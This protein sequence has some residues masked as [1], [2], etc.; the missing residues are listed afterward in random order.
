MFDRTERRGARAA[1]V[2]RDQ[3]DIGLG[4]GHTG[5]DRPDA[6]L[7]HQLHR[8]PGVRIDL[9]QVVDQL[10]QILDRIDVVMRRRADQADARRRMAHAGDEFGDLETG[11][12]AALARLGAL[13]HLDLDLA[14]LVQIFGRDTEPA[15]GDLLDCAVGVVAV[16]ARRI[17]LGVLAAL[18]GDRPRADP[19]HGDVQRLVRL[20]RQG[21]QRHAGRDEPAADVVGALDLIHRHRR[22]LAEV[23]QVAQGR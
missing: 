18:A 22:G 21:T 15:G 8:H 12:L 17:A 6:R 20:G 16:R 11:Q 2:A 19:V 14:A 3:D 1:V 9:F 7:G 4:L 5:G 23:Q 13:G 10:G